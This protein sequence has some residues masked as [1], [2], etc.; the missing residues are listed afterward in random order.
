MFFFK[1]SLLAEFVG[2][3]LVVFVYTAGVALAVR[4]CF[5]NGFC[6]SG[7]IVCWCDIG[8]PTTEKAAVSRLLK[9]ETDTC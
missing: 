5:L 3:K 2:G 6:L 7:V 9:P 4:L 1:L 8:C